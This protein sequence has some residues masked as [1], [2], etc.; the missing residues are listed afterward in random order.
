MPTYPYQRREQLLHEI[1]RQA[2]SDLNQGRNTASNPLKRRT[3]ASRLLNQLRPFK[4]KWMQEHPE[5]P[6]NTTHQP[7]SGLTRENITMNDKFSLD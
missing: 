6:Q 7:T 2:D 1:M 3:K 4:I 5:K